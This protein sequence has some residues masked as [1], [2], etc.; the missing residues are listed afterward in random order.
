M[1]LRARAH[2]NCKKRCLAQRAKA[3]AA[4]AKTAT[5]LCD[6]AWSYANGRCCLKSSILIGT[7]GPLP[8]I[9]GQQF[10]CN[11]E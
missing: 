4:G 5:D 11:A 6:G 3:W 9:V 7:R 8:G 10:T 2:A 1:A